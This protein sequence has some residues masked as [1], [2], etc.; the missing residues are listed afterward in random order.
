M[1]I[2]ILDYGA[3]NLRSVKNAF[4]FLGEEVSFV[5]DFSSNFSSNNYDA[6]VLPG[7]GNFE[8]IARKKFDFNAINEKP[9]LGICLG[10]Q[11]L[12]E[13]STESKRSKGLG[14]LKGKCVKFKN[15][16]LKSLKIPHM[17]W[18]KIEIKKN[19]EILDGIEGF[20]YFAHSYYAVPEDKD[21]IYATCNYGV[22]FPA[23]VIKDNIIATQFHPE[24]SGE[25]GLKFLKNF[26]KFAEK[27]L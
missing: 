22:D 2:A 18:N 14:I 12:F 26:L 7:V 8:S 5:S 25:L 1:K 4:E 10:L 17:G 21:I 19:S 23:V 15:K 24:K 13:G 6:F 16:S 20:F 11:V 9:F 27:N 3:G